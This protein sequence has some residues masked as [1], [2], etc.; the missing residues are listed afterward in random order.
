[1]GKTLKLCEGSIA[2]TKS[3]SEELK[4][5][6]KEVFVNHNTASEEMFKLN[7]KALKFKSSLHNRDEL[8]IGYFSGIITHNSDIEIE[9]PAFIKILKEFKNLKLFFFG[10]LDILNDLKKFSSQKK[11]L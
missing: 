3:Q 6:V 10:E 2:S 8:V 5:Y 4:N 11:N 1:M 7:Q 9:I